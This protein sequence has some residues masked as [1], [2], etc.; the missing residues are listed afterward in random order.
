MSDETSFRS[1][2]D[3]VRAGDEQA[4]EELIRLYLRPIRLV[5]RKRLRD[6]ALRTL[7]ESMDICQ[8]ILGGFFVRMALGQFDLQTPEDLRK[9]LVTMAENKIRNHKRRLEAA[10]RD[11]RRTH[12]PDP[13]GPEFVDPTPSPGRIVANKE[14]LQEVRRRLSTEVRQIADL[15]AAGHSWQEIANQLGQAPDVLRMR[16]QRAVNRLAKEMGLEE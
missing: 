12:G 10:R 5:V 7:L 9:L 6:P 8:S 13:A 3:R 1:L 16:H 11:Y 4:A 2:L 15:R 14:L